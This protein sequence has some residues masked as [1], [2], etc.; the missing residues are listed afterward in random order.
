MPRFGLFHKVITLSSRMRHRT[1]NHSLEK[2][3]KRPTS[4]VQG[5]GMGRVRRRVLCVSEIMIYMMRTMSR[6]IVEDLNRE[7]SVGVS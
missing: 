6:M 7:S 4:A 1:K 2:W 5:N 3:K